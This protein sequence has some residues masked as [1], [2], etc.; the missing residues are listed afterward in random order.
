MVNSR[1]VL[2]GFDYSPFTIHYLPAH[3]VS[4]VKRNFLYYSLPRNRYRA[5][6][7]AVDSSGHVG[8]ERLGK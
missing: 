3:H 5:D 8:L 1:P 6:T 7:F 2:Y 4:K